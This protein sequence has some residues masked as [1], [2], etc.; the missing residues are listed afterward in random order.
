LFWVLGK[1]DNAVHPDAIARLI[2]AEAQADQA[3][4]LLPAEREARLDA[5][6]HRELERLT[7]PEAR[8]DLAVRALGQ[9]IRA[10]RELT[11]APSGVGVSA[12]EVRG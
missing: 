12:L 2:A 9:E 7:D 5:E 3:P 10:Y 11:P 4:P 1:P 6:L 8:L